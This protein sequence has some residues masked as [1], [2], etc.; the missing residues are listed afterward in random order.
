MKMLLY[1]RTNFKIAQF[2]Y[3]NKLRG[4]FTKRGSPPCGNVPLSRTPIPRVPVNLRSNA[5][6]FIVR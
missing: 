6:K 1:P 4:G 2:M 5:A 3:A